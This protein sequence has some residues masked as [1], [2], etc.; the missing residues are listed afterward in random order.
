MSIITLIIISIVYLLIKYPSFEKI[1]VSKDNAEKALDRINSWATW[2][3]GLQTAALASIVFII[4]ESEKSF[5][6]DQSLKNS[7]FYALLFFGSSILLCTWLLSSIS[8]IQQRLNASESTENDV[9]ENKIFSFVDIKLGK[10]SG[11]VHLY[12]I[13][14][15][16]FYSIFLFNWLDK[17]FS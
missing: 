8:S 17:G 13:I 10:F 5:C 2:L 14:G 4:K 15:I 9:F 6:I 1:S 7:V 12:F 3:T 16:I 11:L